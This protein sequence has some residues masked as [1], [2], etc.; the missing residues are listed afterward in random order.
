M[1]KELESKNLLD[2]D[3]VEFIKE[4]PDDGEDDSG[5]IPISPDIED[6]SLID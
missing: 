6:Y 5:I 3:K 1:K 4:D 2:K